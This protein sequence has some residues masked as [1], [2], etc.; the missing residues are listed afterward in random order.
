MQNVKKK[1]TI[2]EKKPKPDLLPLRR[3]FQQPRY[4]QQLQKC[5]KL[6]QFQHPETFESLGDSRVAASSPTAPVRLG[7]I[8][9]L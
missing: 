5:Q 3:I 7:L 6:G 2:L 9:I 8:A 1:I 4:A